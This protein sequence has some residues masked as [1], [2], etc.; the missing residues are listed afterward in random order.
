MNEELKFNASCQLAIKIERERGPLGRTLLPDPRRIE[1]GI[2]VQTN[3]RPGQTRAAPRRAEPSRADTEIGLS[4]RVGRK[5]MRARWLEDN[6]HGRGHGRRRRRRRER[7]TMRAWGASD[8]PLEV[9][10]EGIA[11][12]I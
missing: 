10:V 12:A 4:E 7:A 5:L 3:G 1:A 9:R 6:G 8:T 11:M 2:H